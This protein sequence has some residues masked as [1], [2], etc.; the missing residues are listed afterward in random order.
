MEGISSF[1]GL[2]PDF[3]LQPWRKIEWEEDWE[4]RLDG[5]RKDH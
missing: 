3:I 1:P 4:L 2:L 5:R